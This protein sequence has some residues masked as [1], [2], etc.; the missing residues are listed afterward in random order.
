M[1]FLVALLKEWECQNPKAGAQETEE[2]GKPIVYFV[3]VLTNKACLEIRDTEQP[4]ALEDL[5]VQNLRPNGG[6]SV[7]KN[8]QTEWGDPV[9]TCLRSLSPLPNAGIKD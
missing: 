8:P 3:C 5:P 9:S 4:A 6:D 7:S 2:K 1:G